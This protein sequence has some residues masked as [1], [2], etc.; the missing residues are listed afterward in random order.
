MCVH[1][2]LLNVTVSIS[3]NRV[4]Q[5]LLCSGFM[6]WG[7]IMLSSLYRETETIEVNC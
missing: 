3:S 2:L 1:A 6:F 4:S 7:Q 5:C